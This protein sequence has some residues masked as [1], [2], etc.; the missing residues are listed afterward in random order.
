MHHMYKVDKFIFEFAMGTF[1]KIFKKYF[2]N[3]NTH[4]ML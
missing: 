1:F 4:N 2:D 3:S